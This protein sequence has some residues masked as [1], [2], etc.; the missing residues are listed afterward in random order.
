MQESNKNEMFK[1]DPKD[2]L[3]S[4][5]PE[6]LDEAKKGKGLKIV[7]MNQ[8]AYLV[9][10]VVALLFMMMWFWS[11]TSKENAKIKEE[12]E[13][14]AK[15]E[16]SENY[17]QNM[18][19]KKQE[20]GLVQ[21]LPKPKAPVIPQTNGLVGAKPPLPEPI[22]SKSALLPPSKSSSVS[23]M[24]QDE[25]QR[26]LV[27]ARYQLFGQAVNSK[28]SVNFEEARAD[29]YQ[30][31]QIRATSSAINE[32][33]QEYQRKLDDARRQL[34]ATRSGGGIGALT[35]S[36]GM[37]LLNTESSIRSGVDERVP[38]SEA[39][40]LDA[41]VSTPS[42]PY[43]LQTGFV[44]PAT[45]ITGI[46]SDL[47]GKIVAQISQNVYDTATGRHLLIPQG[48]KI[49]GT[50][51]SQVAF[52]QSR[53]LVGWNR[54]IFPDGKTL[55][56]G[57]MPGAT[58]AGYSGFE[59]KVNNHYFR[60]FGAAFM[61]S[62][63]TAGITWSQDRNE[64]N[65]DDGTSASEA[66]SE[67]LGQQLGQTASQLIQRHLNVAPTLEIR[68]GFRFNV[69]VTKDMVFNRPYKSFDY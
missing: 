2:P 14:V 3:L 63:V 42:S 67:A 69:I 23:S 52:G 44:M 58:G 45:L 25:E 38:S 20:G 12:Q 16:S 36:G 11:S 68:P 27:R 56:I 9:V 28:T 26:E 8:M 10:A 29:R 53:V 50:Y 21:P 1:I 37:Q 34:A 43:E 66:M 54:L 22:P 32:V 17:A 6:Q 5:T 19:L 30:S 49:W 64:D 61:M 33:T 18:L 60:L 15:V 51:S 47:P 31:R 41:E 55:D 59:D 13:T 48:T 4:A 7:R 24:K 46:N 57:E 39:W 35:G 62:A 65:D 40:K